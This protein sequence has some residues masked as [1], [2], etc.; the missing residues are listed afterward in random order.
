[1]RCQ[2][3]IHSWCCVLTI[4]VFYT[5]SILSTGVAYASAK[6]SGP[7]AF[8]LPLG[9]QLIPPVFIFIGALLVPESP[10]WLTARGKKDQAAAILAKYHGGGDVLH[11]VVQ[12]ELREFEESIK[13]QKAQSVWNYYDLSV[14]LSSRDLDC[15]IELMV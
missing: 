15:A 4:S 2:L 6:A 5:G 14:T 12:L 11:P 8:R 3:A 13:V 1:V 10:R 7:L 9:L